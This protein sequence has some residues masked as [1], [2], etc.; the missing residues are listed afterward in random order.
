MSK[1]KELDKLDKWEKGQTVIRF[2]S[3]LGACDSIV[4]IDKITDGRGGTIYVGTEK[5]DSNGWARGDFGYHRPHIKIATEEDIARVR[6]QN[7]SRRLA[8]FDWTKLEPAEAYRI[9]ELLKTNGV[10]IK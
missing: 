2:S 6:G 8:R 5:Y 10:N 9:Y 1:T 3:G 7:A 4:K